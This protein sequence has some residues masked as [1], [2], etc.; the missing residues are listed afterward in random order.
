MKPARIPSQTPPPRGQNTKTKV[1]RGFAK[2]F[3]RKLFRKTE[4]AFS[5]RHTARILGRQNPERKTSFPFSG[6]I[7]PSP[8]QKCKECFFFRG[9]PRTRRAECERIPHFP[10]LESSVLRTEARSA[11]GTLCISNFENRF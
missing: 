4:S 9:C 8:N 11:R 2:S 5:P 7:S 10:F 3:P 1:S 6:E